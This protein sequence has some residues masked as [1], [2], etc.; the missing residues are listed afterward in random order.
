MT[1]TPIITPPIVDPAEPG[2]TRPTDP[3][4]PI[5]PD[6]AEPQPDRPFPPD[7]PEPGPDE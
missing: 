3:F 2:I 5:G 1:T 4:P 6:P 7:Q